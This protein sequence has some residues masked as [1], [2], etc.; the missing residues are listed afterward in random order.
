GASGTRK[1]AATTLPWSWESKRLK[2]SQDVSDPLKWYSVSERLENTPHQVHKQT[3]LLLPRH[4]GVVAVMEE[5]ERRGSLD[6]CFGEHHTTLLD[7]FERLT[8]EIQLNRAILRRSYS[9]PIA[10]RTT[11]PSRPQPAQHPPKCAEPWRQR[12]LFRALRRLFKPAICGRRTKG[13]QG[14]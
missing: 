8:F 9:E 14:V 11:Q 5:E 2:N 13:G 1:M 3:P 6:V 7:E 12:R 10:A 4:Y